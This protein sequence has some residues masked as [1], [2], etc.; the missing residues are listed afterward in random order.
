MKRIWALQYLRALAAL[1]VLAYHVLASSN[2]RSS[3]GNIGVDVFFVLSGFLMFSLTAGRPVSPMQFLADRVARIAPIYWVA[4]IGTF[5]LACVA[6]THLRN[7][8][9]DPGLLVSSLFFVPHFNPEGWIWPTVFV[10]WSLNFEM[11]FYVAFAC[12]LGLSDRIRLLALSL[13]FVG[14]V[15]AGQLVHEQNPLWLTYTSPLLLEFLSGAWIGA[16]FRTSERRLLQPAAVAASLG[17]VLILVLVAGYLL[18]RIVHGWIAVM[19]VAAG[20][21]F[22]NAGKMPQVALLKL[23][24][25]ASYSIYLFQQLAINSVDHALGLLAS[26]THDA[27][28]RGPIRIPFEF[29]AAV[30]L[31][32]AVQYCLEKRLTRY[33]RS[34]LAKI[35]H[36]P[37]R[38]AASAAP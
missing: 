10:G 38:L 28:T 1:G 11:F 19:L 35:I 12:A 32:V 21:W 2:H 34:M 16:V 9:A 26:V 17:A 29:A 3:L 25:D 15:L 7:S 4:T 20:V 36:G 13:L 22:E 8:Y 23:L 18:P 6:P 30:A 27:A 24:G 31:G 37:S 5:V 33:A 14:F